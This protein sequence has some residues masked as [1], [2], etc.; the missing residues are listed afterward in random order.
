MGLNRSPQHQTS[1]SQLKLNEMPAC[2]RKYLH[3]VES[4]AIKTRMSKYNKITGTLKIRILKL[5]PLKKKMSSV[6]LLKENFKIEAI[7]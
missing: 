3:S 5:S 2:D 4:S 7:F 1:V 6:I